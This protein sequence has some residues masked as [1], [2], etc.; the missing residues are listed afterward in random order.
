MIEVV[1][2][3]KRFDKF[4]V[5]E[6]LNFQIDDGKICGLVGVNGAGKSTLLRIMAGIYKAEF[7]EVLY[8]GRSVYEN[9][10]V[11]AQIAFVP[12]DLFLPGNMS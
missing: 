7:G 9:C 6:N 4:T 12:D 2:L 10:D 11:K 3:C 5:F 1:K 8:N